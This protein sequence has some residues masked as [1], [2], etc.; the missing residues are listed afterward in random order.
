[1]DSVTRFLE[2]KLK[3][4]VNRDKSDVDRPW[5]RKF[6]GYSFL[7]QKDA[8]LKVAPE[9]LKRAKETLK[10]YFAGVGAGTLIEL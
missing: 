9:S 3:L 5:K 7:S 6:L 4:V 1:M 8:K 2:K 10:K